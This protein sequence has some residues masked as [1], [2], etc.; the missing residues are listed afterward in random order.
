M[1]LAAV[2]L[3]IASTAQA[4]GTCAPSDLNG[5]GTKAVTAFNQAGVAAGWWCPG[6]SRPKLY[7]VRWAG[8]TQQLHEALDSLRTSKDP[9]TAISAMANA[10]TNTPIS[11]LRD[12]WGPM[13]ASLMASRPTWVVAPAASNAKPPGTRPAYPWANGARGT[14]SNGR[15]MEGTSC[16]PTV[17]RIEGSTAYYGVNARTDQVAVCVRD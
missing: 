16:N 4:Q 13:E 11:E 1:R 6:A 2:C 3:L 7:A 9:A 12:V 17:G 8:A 15:A 5:T 14:V 10:N